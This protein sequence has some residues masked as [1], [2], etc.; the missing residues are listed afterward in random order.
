MFISELIRVLQERL[1]TEGDAKIQAHNRDGDLQDIAGLN[2]CLRARGDALL[3]FPY[4]D[5]ES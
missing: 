2:V 3:E 5:T 4:I 1:D